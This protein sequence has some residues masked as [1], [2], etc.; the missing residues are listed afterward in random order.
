MRYRIGHIY[1]KSKRK[2]RIGHIYV[3]KAREEVSEGGC[4]GKGQDQCAGEGD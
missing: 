1:V 4:K 3:P 2:P